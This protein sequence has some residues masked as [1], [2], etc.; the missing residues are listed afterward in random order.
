MQ[1]NFDEHLDGKL[2]PARYVPLSLDM[3]INTEINNQ[4]SEEQTHQFFVKFM[5]VN[6]F[7]DMMI[8]YQHDHKMATNDI[9]NMYRTEFMEQDEC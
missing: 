2:T 3:G 9:L 8:A 5:T 7:A 6:L 1:I 4:S